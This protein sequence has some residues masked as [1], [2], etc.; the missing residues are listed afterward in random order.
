MVIVF[1]TDAIYNNATMVVAFGGWWQSRRDTFGMLDWQMLEG[2][3][4][5]TARMQ[6][7]TQV[8]LTPFFGQRTY[9]DD[10]HAGDH[11]RYVT[12]G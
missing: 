4:V 10:G 9:A 1:Y 6:S 8:Y 12:I 7:G 2:D 11:R 5:Q 3:R